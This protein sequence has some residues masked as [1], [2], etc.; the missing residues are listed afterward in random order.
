[1]SL[2]GKEFNHLSGRATVHS[3]GVDVWSVRYSGVISAACFDGLRRDVLQ[4]TQ[5]AQSMILRMDTA[6]TLSTPPIPNGTYAA[7]TAPGVVVVREDQHA[8]WLE[9]ARRVARLGIIRAVFLQRDLVLARQ[10]MDC[11][12]GRVLAELPAVH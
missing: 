4:T 5:G 11:F 9:Y 2:L 7:N 6:L 1:M 8:V 10:V 12:A 3:L